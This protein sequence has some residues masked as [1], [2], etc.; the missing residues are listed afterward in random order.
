M[1]ENREIPAWLKAAVG[2]SKAA[3]YG[4]S[5]CKTQSALGGLRTV[6]REARCPNRGECFSLGDATIMILGDVCT[7]GCQFCAVQKACKPLPPSPE[8]PAQVARTAR[9][10]GLKYLVL[11]M[12]T[13]DDLPDGG[14]RHIYET[15]AAVRA[16][17]PHCETEPLISDLGGKF[18]HLPLIL[19]GGCAVLA[20]NVETVPSLYAA[21]RAGAHYR[22]S[23]RLLEEAKK[24]NPR[25]LTKSGLM[26]GM[27]ESEAELKN[28]LNDLRAA[29]CDLL[30]LGQYLAP[31]AGHYAV[32]EY[33]EQPRYDMLK[34][35]ALAAGFKGVMAGPL[36]RSSYKA[37]LL[38][39]QARGL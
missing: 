7:R 4:Q 31:S 35:F 11:T 39:A 16:A 28:V 32:R 38:Y 6:C 15:T 34:E 27:G 22:R 30:T 10:L 26:L 2:K 29:G 14:A 36:V 20:H 37:G 25:V 12:P 17:C 24:I 23:L 3:F 21:V 9:E 18:E 13:R 5:A 33:P 8:E 19:S 1:E